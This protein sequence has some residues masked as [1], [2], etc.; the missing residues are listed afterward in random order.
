M[1]APKRGF[2]LI[3]LLVVIAII[4]ILI[5]LLLPAVQKVRAAAARTKC[6]NHLKQLG[7]ALHNYHDVN[8]GFPSSRDVDQAPVPASQQS[9]YRWSAFARVSPYL[10]QT[11]IYNN[12]DLKQPLY[13]YSFGPPPAVS[14]VAQH[15]PWIKLDLPTFR[16][17]SDPTPR[18]NA[19]WGPTN[20][21]LCAGSGANGGDY[22][23]GDGI[24][25]IDARVSIVQ[26]VRGTS[27]T[28]LV[29]ES[30]LG[31]GVGSVPAGFDVNDRGGLER[32]GDRTARPGRVCDLA[33]RDGAEP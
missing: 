27:N 12:L 8:Q 6:Q 11:A 19:E 14:V 9:F 23:K 22:E 21:A 25:F 3:E 10:E 7:L 28:G 26:I 24:F 15:E 33:G 4:A 29:S 16:C 32:G 31:T 5:G 20:Y 2:T 17:P 18:T 13:L 1:T 30:L